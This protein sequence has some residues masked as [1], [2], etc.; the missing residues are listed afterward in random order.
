MLVLGWQGI[1][2]IIRGY[3]GDMLC[4][5]RCLPPAAALPA[6]TWSARNSREQQRRASI[7]AEAVQQQGGAAPPPAAAGS[8]VGPGEGAAGMQQNGMSREGEAVVQIGG[9]VQRGR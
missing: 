7:S 5:R 6:M 8:T 2:S 1:Q 3:E 9:L 4:L